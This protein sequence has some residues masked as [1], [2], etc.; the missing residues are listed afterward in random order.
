MSDYAINMKIAATFSINYRMYTGC[1]YIL[2]WWLFSFCSLFVLS[3]QWKWQRCFLEDYCL[4]LA[5]ISLAIIS[6]VDSFSSYR[7]GKGM[8]D[9]I[10]L[11]ISKWKWMTSSIDF[12]LKP[13]YCIWITS[14]ILKCLSLTVKVYYL[15]ISFLESFFF[16]SSS[17]TSMWRIV[18]IVGTWSVW[19]LF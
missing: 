14:S 15:F 11:C 2:L 9:Q 7:Y 4:R 18:G 1:F 5:L 3:L 16:S 10:T 13:F 19:V 12:L 17:Y 8:Y 6:L